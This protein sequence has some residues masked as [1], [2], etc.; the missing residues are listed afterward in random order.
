M[1]S[2]LV[3]LLTT[4]P[5]AAEFKIVNEIDYF[6]VS[7]DTPRELR[8]AMEKGCQ[9][10][11]CTGEHWAHTKWRVKW[12][13][14]YGREKN[15]CRLTVASVTARVVY[16]LPRWPGKVGAA[17]GL[18]AKW[19]AMREKLEAHERNHGENG[20]ETA[21]KIER[22]LLDLPPAADCDALKDS[23]AATGKRLIAEGNR[24]DDAYDERTDH[25]KHEGISLR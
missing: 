17:P 21:R 9:A 22:A 23:I 15:G 25:G 5:L 12:R 19:E 16:T 2:V 14:K 6:D 8:R 13:Y 7:G 11:A 24:W 20:I 3:F 1:V 18:R 10:K 4:G